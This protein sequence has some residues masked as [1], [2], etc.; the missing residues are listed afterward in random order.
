VRFLFFFTIYLLVSFVSVAQTV[1]T[2]GNDTTIC[3][4]GTAD[5]KGTVVS[6]SYG[7][8]SY[9][10]ETFN[11]TPELFSGGFPIQFGSNQDDQIAG[12]FN[13]GFSFCFFNQIYT[14]FYIGSN[15]WVGFS[16]DA[17]WTTFTAQP[18][19]TTNAPV[20]KNCIMAPWQDWWPGWTPSGTTHPR[21]PGSR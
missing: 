20:P 10:F 9:T 16:Y 6:G 12:P 5:L 18:I 4:G 13:I 15:G 1:I 14:E 8:T 7:T 19:P 21:S 11:Y 17:A 2:A 3:L